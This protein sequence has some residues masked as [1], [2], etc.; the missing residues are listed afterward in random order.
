MNPAIRLFKRALATKVAFVPMPGGEQAT[1]P[2]GAPVDPA[3]GGDPA[4]MGG[5]PMDPM[6]AGG[7]PMDPAAMGGAPMDPAAMGMDP[8]AMGMDPS[9]MDPAAMPPEEGGGGDGVTAAD[10]ETVDKITRRTL[11]IVRETLDM[12]G[13]TKG[14]KPAEGAEAA[15]AE[16]VLPPGPIT[17]APADMSGIGALPGM[18]KIA[19]LFLPEDLDL[20]PSK[21]YVKALNRA[22]ASGVKPTEDLFKRVKTEWDDLQAKRSKTASALS[23]LGKPK[24]VKTAAT[25]S[26]LSRLAKPKQTKI[27]QTAA[28]LSGKKGLA[29]FF[30][31]H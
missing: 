18:P 13:K 28:A 3:A 8:A 7:A 25:A 29:K 12:V 10:A 11:D 30:S 2:G 27:A 17:G 1:G 24:E 20:E 21:A 22:E 26:V 5:A 15:P 9:M 14:P 23:R 19:S 4:A 31:E 6:A 16:P